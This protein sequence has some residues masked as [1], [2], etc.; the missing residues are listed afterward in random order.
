MAAFNYKKTALR[1]ALLFTVL[2]G[3]TLPYDQESILGIGVMLKPWTEWIVRWLGQVI[4]PSSDHMTGLITSDSVGLYIH[5]AWLLTVT[6]LLSTIWSRLSTAHDERK[7]TYGLM[8]FCRYFLAIFLFKYGLVK[9]LHLQ[10]FTPDPNTLF[11]PMGQL[12]RD[13]LYWSVM[14]ISGSYSFFLGTVELIAGLLLLWRSTYLIGALMA[15]GVM[16]HVLAVNI[17]FD[18]SVKLFSMYLLLLSIV[19]ITPHISQLITF[20]IFQQP[21]SLIKITITYSSKRLRQIHTLLKGLVVLFC[22]WE[23]ASVLVIGEYHAEYSKLPKWVGAYDV[24]GFQPMPTPW[25]KRVFIHR[26]RYLITQDL[27]DRFEDHPLLY[28][29]D[30]VILSSL[31][32]GDQIRFSLHDSLGIVDVI[33]DDYRIK[34]KRLDWKNLPALQDKFHWTVEGVGSEF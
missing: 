30:S 6:L 28:L 11:T 14:G 19:L 4:L 20:F 10:F 25:I 17:G 21:S 1:W 31:R 32:E 16:A 24:I 3:L 33:S 15:L 13:I 2:F 7:L 18:I 34:L 29:S 23:G 22:V 26:D 5:T 12:D 27:N 9:V 8:V